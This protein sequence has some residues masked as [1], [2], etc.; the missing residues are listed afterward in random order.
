MQS[1]KG[2]VF[3]VSIKNKEIFLDLV[4]DNECDYSL[5][6]AKDLPQL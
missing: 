2:A 3:D 6:I 4:S 1:Q 5:E